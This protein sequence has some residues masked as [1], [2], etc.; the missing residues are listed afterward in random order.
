MCAVKIPDRT[1]ERSKLQSAVATYPFE[2]PLIAQFP[3]CEPLEE[4]NID[5]IVR[6]VVEGVR[7]GR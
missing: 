1:R 2:L 3:G 7:C 6:E 5:V 4:I